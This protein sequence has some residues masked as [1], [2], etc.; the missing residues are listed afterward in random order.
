MMDNENLVGELHDYVDEEGY[1][2]ISKLLDDVYKK[3]RQKAIHDTLLKVLDKIHP[4]TDIVQL[5]VYIN[6]MIKE[7]EA[8]MG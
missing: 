5:E 6:N 3:A 4:K 7:V 1:E 2:A 8:E